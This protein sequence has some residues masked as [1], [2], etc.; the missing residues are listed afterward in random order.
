MSTYVEQSLA[1]TERI[2]YR[3]QWPW[4]FWFWAWMALILFGVFL[5]GIFIFVRSAVKMSTT[6]FAV[7]NQRVILKRG[8]LNRSTDELAVESVEGVELEQN[9]IERL[10]GYGKL[11]V[12]GKGDTHIY[13]PPMRDP[14]SFRRAIGAGREEASVEEVVLAEKEAVSARAS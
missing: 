11:I 2:I 8:W 6:E 14:V 10:F 5:V 9:F 3:G 4:I 13:F 7:T 12:S 1:P